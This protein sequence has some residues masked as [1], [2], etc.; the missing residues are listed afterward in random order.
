MEKLTFEIVPHPRW[1]GDWLLKPNR[2]APFGLWYRDRD[3]AVSYAEWVGREVDCA[4][5]RV[6]NWRWNP[7]R[8]SGRW[9]QRRGVK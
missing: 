4:E 2:G 7:G 6:F 9:A 3:H 8:V 5:I 1:R